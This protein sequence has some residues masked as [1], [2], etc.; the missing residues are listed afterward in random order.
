F[1]VGLN[2]ITIEVGRVNNDALDDL[3]IVNRDS[4]NISVMTRRAGG[5]FN[6]PVNYTVGV[7]PRDV[8]IADLDGDGD[9]DL[10]VA[11]ETSGTVTVLYNNGAG[12]FPNANRKTFNVPGSPVSI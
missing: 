3:V 6:F 7:N 8:V 11:N 4:N 10:A 9:R 5:G 12:V 1:P 2:P